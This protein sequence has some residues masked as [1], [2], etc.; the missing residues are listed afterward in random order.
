M[1]KRGGTGTGGERQER[2]RAHARER[3]GVR[4]DAWISRTAHRDLVRLARR[5][6]C[7]QARAI[8]RALREAA[9][10]AGESDPRGD[11]KP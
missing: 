9:L 4:I 11:H 1:T 10:R 8:E 3:G 7:T 6:E 2:F 5:W